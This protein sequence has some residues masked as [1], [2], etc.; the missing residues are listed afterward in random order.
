M[1][2]YGAV[3]RLS[4][5]RVV[6]TFVAPEKQQLLNHQVHV[7]RNVNRRSSRTEPTRR[8]QYRIKTRCPT[9]TPVCA[10]STVSARAKRPLKRATVSKHA[11]A[12]SVVEG[13][14]N[15]TC[16]VF[17][18]GWAFRHSS[19]VRIADWLGE[20]GKRESTKKKNSESSV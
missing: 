12:L 19:C 10:E 6:R 1:R 14:T 4:C 7:Q 9:T 8:N 15:I 16:T 17:W 13:T 11:L 3:Q 20:N 5:G 18:E 2:R